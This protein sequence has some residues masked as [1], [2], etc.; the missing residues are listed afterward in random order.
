MPNDKSVCFLVVAVDCRIFKSEN[1][2]K[3]FKIELTDVEASLIFLFLANS[4]KRKISENLKANNQK[5]LH[6]KS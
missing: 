2:I 1:Q 3:I 5:N 6:K 4:K